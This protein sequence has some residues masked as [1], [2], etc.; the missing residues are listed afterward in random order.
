M[1]QVRTSFFHPGLDW[2]TR[3]SH[4]VDM[5]REMSRQTDPQVMVQLYGERVSALESFD[6]YISLSRRGLEAPSFRITRDSNWAEDVDPWKEKHR[7]PLLRGGL[8]SELIYSN[9]PSFIEDLKVSPDDPAAPYLKG[10]STLIAVPHY[11]GGE[12]LNMVVNL[13][14]EPGFDPEEIPQLVWISSLFG[15]AT[16][17]LRLAAQLNE[18]NAAL[19]RELALVGEIQRTEQRLA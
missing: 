3:L 15:R 8:L 6:R 9:Q 11:D 1:P 4:I 13:W 16:Y 5:M 18:A 19:D 10:Y 14:R 17:T 7:L 12:S 2:R